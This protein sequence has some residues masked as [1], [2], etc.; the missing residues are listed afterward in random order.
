M[1]PATIGQAARQTGL[2]IDAIRF[3]ERQGLLRRPPRTDGGFRLF[4]AAEIRALQFIHRAQQLGFSLRE[5][6]ELL[7][8]E[9]DHDHACRHVQQLLERKLAAVRAKIAELEAMEASLQAG[10]RKC[11]RQ[12]REDCG[13]TKRPCPVLEEMER[14]QT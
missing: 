4:G 1:S 13:P 3:Y 11:R 2:S 8:L 14:S 5:I 7:V 9:S 12:S 6:H 10:L